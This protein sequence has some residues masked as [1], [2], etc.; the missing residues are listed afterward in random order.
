MTMTTTTTHP[1]MRDTVMDVEA[2]VFQIL[3]HSASSPVVTEIPTEAT[4]AVTEL[5]TELVTGNTLAKLPMEDSKLGGIPHLHLR[6][7]IRPL[8]M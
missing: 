6:L 1:M 3:R 5:V 2:V 4:E 8:A 7:G